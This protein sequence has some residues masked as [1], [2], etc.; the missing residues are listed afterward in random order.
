ML[1][2]LA[3][4]K[5]NKIDQQTAAQYAQQIQMDPSMREPANTVAELDVDIQIDEVQDTPT[6]Q[7]EQFEQLAK[8]A[9]M[10]PPQYLPTMFELMVEASNLRNK[11]KLRSVMEEAKQA[12]AQPNPMQQLQ[13]EGAQAEVEKTK[14]EA[15][16]NMATA[17]ATMAKTEVDA[18][19]MGVSAAA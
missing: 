12:Q 16:K 2:L 14:S 8:L 13:M 19:N 11:D 1:K 5:E 15:A 17:Q 7:I 9:P 4:V 3:A 10:A 18:F 6:L